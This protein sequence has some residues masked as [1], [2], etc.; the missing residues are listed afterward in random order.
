M[1]KPRGVRLNNPGNLRHSKDKWQ[2]KAS[3]QPDAS[4]VQFTSPQFGIRAMARVLIQYEK[5][6]VNTV[7]KVIDRWAPAVE[8]DTE[9]YIAHVAQLLDADPD[10][11]IDID[12]FEVMFPLVKAIIAHENANYAYPDKL[13][14]DALRM[15]GVHD[16]PAKKLTE[17]GGFKTQAVAA[18][19][20][21]LGVVAAVAEPV[22]KAAD[23]LEPFT[24]SPIIGQVV[25]GLLTLAGAATLAGVIGTWLK[26]RKGL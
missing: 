18:T 23:G 22:K 14:T 19:A 1:S 24:G 13:V 11:I 21:G 26:A 7:R 20:S 3:E 16:A 8:N 6:G 17:Q 15:A 5:A 12:S 4:F 9:A 2:G 10:Q 25:I